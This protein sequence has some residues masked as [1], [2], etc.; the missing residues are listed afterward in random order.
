MQQHL[1]AG[2]DGA[3]SG[4]QNRTKRPER[5]A[6]APGAHPAAPSGEAPAPMQ[7][8]TELCSFLLSCQPYL[9]SHL[10]L[11]S[12]TN[13]TNTLCHQASVREPAW[14]IWL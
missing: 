4:L 6:T 11:K 1:R 13:I 14:G 2:Q 10:G 7:P 12:T 9:I 3:G 5:C 8:L